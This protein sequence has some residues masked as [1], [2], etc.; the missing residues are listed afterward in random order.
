ML[1]DSEEGSLFSH[2]I[3]FLASH[4]SSIDD[5]SSF[6]ITGSASQSAAGKGDL[7]QSPFDLSKEQSRASF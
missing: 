6:N 2:G 4:T 7:A 5:I 1:A 3:S